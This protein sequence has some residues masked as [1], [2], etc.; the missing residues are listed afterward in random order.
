MTKKMTKEELQ[1]MYNDSWIYIMLLSTIVILTESLKNY[2]FVLTTKVTYAIFLIPVIL[3]I[4]NYIT[5]K[6]GFKRSL[7]AIAIST[8]SLIAFVAIMYFAIGIN[9][10]FSIVSGQVVGYL[11]CQLV[12]L[13]IYC[14]LLNNTSSPYIL[15]LINYIFSLIAF[16]LAY[17]V[18]Q[19]DLVIGKDF[20]GGYFITLVIQLVEIIIITLFDKSIKRGL[21]SKK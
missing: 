17:T 18:M 13:F 12:N 11:V 7:L 6:Y 2:T 20:W 4:T 16:Y 3:L 5:K 21:Y 19:A 8:L 1:E 15:V 14:F 10:S 9:F